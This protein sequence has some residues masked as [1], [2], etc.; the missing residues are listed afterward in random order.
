MVHSFP[1]SKPD[2]RGERNL[3]RTRNRVGGT[4]I[5]GIG[6]VAIRI[7]IATGKHSR[8]AQCQRKFIA[9]E[10]GEGGF[11]MMVVFIIAIR[12]IDSV[13]PIIGK[14]DSPI[15][16]GVTQID[17]KLPQADKDR[18]PYANPKVGCTENPEF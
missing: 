5:S 4:D 8:P 1:W 7:L 9:E 18:L 13:P 14:G 15:S 12:H 2:R 16:K 3:C 11:K 17:I 10:I 6:T